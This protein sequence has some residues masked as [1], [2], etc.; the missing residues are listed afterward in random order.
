RLPAGLKNCWIVDRGILCRGLLRGLGALKQFAIG[1]ARRNQTIYFAPAQH[2]TG[3][4]K[5][6]YGEKCRV[7][8]L[9]Q[10][11]PERLRKQALKLRVWGQPHQVAVYSAEILLRGVW[12]G[13]AQ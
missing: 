8:E 7:D 3:G 5:R 1:R 2:K 12:R 4:R 6:I 13:R 9:R 10:R 11:F